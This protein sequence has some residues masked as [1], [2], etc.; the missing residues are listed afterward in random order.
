M[1]NVRPAFEE[2]E[3][4]VDEIDNAY[5]EIKCHLIFDIK[6]GENFRRKARFFAGGHTTVTPAC[7][8][9]ASVVT[10]DSVRIAL[11]ITALNDLK[12][13]ACNM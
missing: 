3:G 6:I 2:W 11:T 5:Q 7:M 10:R 9:Y 8:T 12:I 4:T 13:L 1:K